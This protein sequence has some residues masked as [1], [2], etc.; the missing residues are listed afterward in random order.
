[1]ANPFGENH[2]THGKN[3]RFTLSPAPIPISSVPQRLPCY[4][5]V[6]PTVSS[7]SFSVG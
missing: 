3:P 6:P 2:L 1:M 7:S 4:D 5:W